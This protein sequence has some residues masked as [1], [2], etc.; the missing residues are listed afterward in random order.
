VNAAIITD[1][2]SKLAKLEIISDASRLIPYACNEGK[3]FRLDCG[4]KYSNVAA[5]IRPNKSDMPQTDQG[6]PVI[7]SL[8][9]ENI[10]K[11]DKLSTLILEP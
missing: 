8:D 5:G 2:I 3:E 10:L 9:R 4:K 11:M 6:R 7:R 1:A